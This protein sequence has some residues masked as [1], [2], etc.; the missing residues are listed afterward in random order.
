MRDWSRLKWRWSYKYKRCIECNST[1]REHIWKWL[2]RKCLDNK[3]HIKKRKKESVNRWKW[4]RDYFKRNK[5]VLNLLSKM[6]RKR[7][8]WKDCLKIVINWKDRLMPFTTL[9]KPVATC[10]NMWKY[11]EWKVKIRQF[12]LLKTYYENAK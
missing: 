10:K 4:Q 2:C 7:R 1:K 9:E 11:E 12:N 6:Y 8:L 5:E 3:P